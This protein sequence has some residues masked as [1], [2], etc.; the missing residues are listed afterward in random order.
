MFIMLSI[1]LNNTLFVLPG[2]PARQPAPPV[3]V[4]LLHASHAVALPRA[5]RTHRPRTRHQRS[6]HHDVAELVIR[7]HPRRPVTATD[8]R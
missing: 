6:R 4:A 8:A 5:A 7:A 3:S 2:S 1:Y